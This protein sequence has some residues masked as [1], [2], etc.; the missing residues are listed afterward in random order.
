[1]LSSRQ[2]RL[3]GT[4]AV[5]SVI[6][7]LAS[8]LRRCWLRLD[9]ERQPAAVPAGPAGGQVGRAVYFR[10]GRTPILIEL[11]LFPFFFFFFFPIVK[12]PVRLLL[13]YFPALPLV[14][15][16]I[17]Q[18]MSPSEVVKLPFPGVLLTGVALLRCARGMDLPKVRGFFS[19]PPC[20][21]AGLLRLN[22]NLLF[23][24]TGLHCRRVSA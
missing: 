19:G 1:L 22:R 8:V 17:G 4:F 9:L 7:P 24:S 18:P 5:D 23:A 12:L 14:T 3:C 15:L 10:S 20:N 13:R 21:E 2:I 6:V 16:R 11:F